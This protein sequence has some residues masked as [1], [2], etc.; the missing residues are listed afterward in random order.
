M[1]E[2]R[3]RLPPSAQ[4]KLKI[5]AAFFDVLRIIVG[6]LFFALGLMIWVASFFT[7]VGVVV[8]IPL[9]VAISMFG[10]VFSVI[11]SAIAHGVT[12]WI[13]HS[14]GVTLLDR[15]GSK[16]ILRIL[17]QIFSFIPFLPWTYISVGLVIRAVEKED[18]EY[19]ESRG[20]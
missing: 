12:G 11:I 15:G 5:I 7:I 16:F 19:N 17:F 3:E 10:S 20:L 14:H 9:G 1:E 6:G 2:R 4:M 13:Y 8:G 18:R